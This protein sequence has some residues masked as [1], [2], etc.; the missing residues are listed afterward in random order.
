MAAMCL[1]IIG[2]ILPLHIDAQTTTGQSRLRGV[3]LDADTG[4]SLEFVKILY[5]SRG[6]TYSSDIHGC[7]DIPRYPGEQLEITTFGYKPVRVTVGKNGQQRLTVKMR[8]DQTEMSEVE[9]VA[10]KVKYVRKGN[11]A[12]E[13]MQRVIAKNKQ[14][15]LKETHDYYKYNNYQKITL[16]MNNVNPDSLK[17]DGQSKKKQW[18]LDQIMF[19]P[20]NGKHILPVNYEEIVTE[21][22]YRRSPKMERNTIIGKKTEG[23][24]QLIDV[25]SNLNVILNDVF[26]DIDLYQDH[27][28]MLM[29]KFI[30]P[31]GSGATSFYRYFINDTTTVEQDSCICLSFLPNNP[32]DF[33]FSGKL[34]VL[35]DST[36]HLRRC[37]LAIPNSSSVNWVS[38]FKMNL[39]YEK[40]PTGDWVVMKDDMFCELEALQFIPKAAVFRVTRRTDYSFDPIPDKVFEGMGK[41]REVADS[42]DRDSTFWEAHRKEDLSKSERN[43]GDFVDGMK[44]GKAFGFV[45]TA[46]KV[47]LENYVGLGNEKHPAYIDFGPLNTLFSHN[48]HDGFRTR[49]S[50][51]TT[52][53]LSRHWYANAYGTI[54]WGSMKGYGGGEIT[55][56]FDKKAKTPDEYPKRKVFISG[57][58]D[59]A[60]PS[61]RFSEH[62]KDNMFTMFKWATDSLR[63]LYDNIKVGF[64]YE[65]LGGL[66]YKGFYNWE[67]QKGL[68][69]LTGMNMTLSEFNFG[70]RYAPGENIIQT[71][72]RRFKINKNTPV[73]ELKHTAAIKGFLGGTHHSNITEASAS[74][75]IYLGSWG[76]LT[77]F[78]KGS[79]QWNKVPF[80]LLLQPPANTALVGQQN[81]F[82]LM[83]DMEFMAD[84]YAMVDLEWDLNGKLFNRIPFIK[85]FKIREHIGFKGVYG[86]LSEKNTPQRMINGR[87]VDNFDNKF[88]WP[89][90]SGMLKA[91][92]PYMEFIAG[93]H[94]IFNVFCVEYVRR[95]SYTGIPG[96]SDNGVRFKF[97]ASF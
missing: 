65:Q 34:Y 41:D 77:T 72:Q 76:R 69:R 46:A 38:N 17:S 25:G 87:W 16:A 75:R 27:V 80:L 68:G 44:K 71:K 92:M 2:F 21:R 57:A 43:M 30:S 79:I 29:Y 63:Y 59:N 86:S 48:F 90:R 85:K 1:L 37:E 91:D 12:V 56:S 94:N 97:Q 58:H 13:L 4:D 8:L 83:S 47:F 66:E 7:F 61:D 88:L 70:I 11:P 6:K 78:A 81:T 5:K 89:E 96:S 14:S 23:V 9:V 36:L 95:L 45:I 33:G 42:E 15:D 67:R 54:G 74:Y 60:A 26:R 50:F 39:D 40:L 93:I 52:G 84:R 73:F 62:D 51:S 55:Y 18:Y 82:N 49:L 53:N 64:D 28:E 10:K 32:Q 3:V 22:A 35:K 19:C 31:I 24:N 20:Q